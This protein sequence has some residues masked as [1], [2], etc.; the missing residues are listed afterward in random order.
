MV[1]S[2]I[3]WMRN[4]LAGIWFNVWNSVEMSIGHWTH[5]KSFIICENA[6]EASGKI[7]I[8]ES[9]NAGQYG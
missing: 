8:L 2:C 6:Y 7:R 4:Q 5:Q 3:V 1:F 9:W